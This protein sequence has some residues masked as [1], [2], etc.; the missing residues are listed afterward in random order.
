MGS[1]QLLIF[2]ESTKLNFVFVLLLQGDGCTLCGG[3]LNIDGNL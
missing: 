3:T 1:I 2:S